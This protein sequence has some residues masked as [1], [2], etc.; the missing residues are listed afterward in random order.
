MWSVN[1]VLTK[2]DMSKWQIMLVP[3]WQVPYGEDGGHF[4]DALWSSAPPLSSA[5][6]CK[7]WPP[8]N[9]LTLACQR[10][11]NTQMASMNCVS[12]WFFLPQ[13]S[14]RNNCSVIVQKRPIPP[15]PKG[16]KKPPPVY[17]QLL[18][19]LNE[20][21]SIQADNEKAGSKTCISFV[22]YWSGGA[23]RIKEGKCCDGGLRQ[24]E[25]GLVRNEDVK[26]N[27][28]SAGSDA[29]LIL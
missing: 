25:E 1:F 16:R 10:A 11:K 5:S 28:A 13:R 12:R 19:D 23:K 26:I 2:S 4:K 17:R 29:R 7:A 24:E 3:F 21:E 18:Q 22:F 27:E 15:P 14:S 6:L 8:H 9:Y 20:A